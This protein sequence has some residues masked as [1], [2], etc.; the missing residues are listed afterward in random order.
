MKPWNDFLTYLADHG[1]IGPTSAG[2]GFGLSPS[3]VRNYWRRRGWPMPYPGVVALPGVEMDFPHR[4]LAA[5]AWIGEPVAATGVTALRL[6]GVADRDPPRLQLVVPQHRRNRSGPW[7]KVHRCDGAFETVSEIEHVPVTSV[8]WAI[9]DRMV[10]GGPGRPRTH[11]IR[12]I[13]RGQVTLDELEH[14]VAGNPVA[15]GIPRLAGVLEELRR[16]LVD[17][18]LE[19]DVRRVLRSEGWSLWPR[20]FPTA[21]PDGH[22]MHLDIALP[23]YWVAIEC[24]DLH[25]HGTTAFT[26][27]RTRWAQAR[28]ATW[29]LIFV[30]RDRLETD[31]AG[32]LEEVAEAVRSADPARQGAAPVHDCELHGC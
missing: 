20:P 18:G 29:Q 22:V 16:D 21:G 19:L 1:G 30:W 10:F 24:E 28:R 25:T 2:A 26:R 4:A 7:G 6:H 23:R 15:P 14:L 32:F 12:A 9:R 13:Q 5:S 27:D 3:S 17:S 8:A 11:V 31:R